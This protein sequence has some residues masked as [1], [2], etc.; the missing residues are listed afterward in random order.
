MDGEF[1]MSNGSKSYVFMDDLGGFPIIFGNTHGIHGIHIHGIHI[2]HLSFTLCNSRG[3]GK[4]IQV[5][6]KI[7]RSST[8]N[9]S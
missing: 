3:I 1:V 5:P 6:A 2:I 7:V 8:P 4:L 9:S